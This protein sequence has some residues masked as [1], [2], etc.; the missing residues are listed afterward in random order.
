MQLCIYNDEL[1]TVELEMGQLQAVAREIPEGCE[2]TR[3]TPPLK[4]NVS[5]GVPVEEESVGIGE[6]PANVGELD[7]FAEY[8]G[9]KKSFAL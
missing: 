2:L 1:C 6:A 9:L 8:G 4:Q 7:I 3:K 5:P